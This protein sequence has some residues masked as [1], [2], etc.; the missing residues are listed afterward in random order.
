MR[1]MI[2]PAV[3]V[4]NIIPIKYIKEF[5]N[6]SIFACSRK[7]SLD[8]FLFVNFKVSHHNEENWIWAGMIFRSNL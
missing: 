1:L 6:Q 7:T 3:R 2:I 5:L 8:S 4:S